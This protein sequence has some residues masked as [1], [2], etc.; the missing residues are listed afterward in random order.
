MTTV[1]EVSSALLK[2]SANNNA[3]YEMA[4]RAVAR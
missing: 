1:M 3:Y 2:Y 4:S